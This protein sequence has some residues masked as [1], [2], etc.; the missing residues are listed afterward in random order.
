MSSLFVC[1]GIVM[2]IDLKASLV[3]NCLLVRGY[4]FRTNSM[5][6]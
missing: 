6:W 4:Y 5:L 1:Q 3:N 2:T